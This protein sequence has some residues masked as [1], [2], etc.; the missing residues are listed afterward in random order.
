MERRAYF[1]IGDILANSLV[2][3]AAVALSAWL[4]GGGPGMWPG[5][6]AG[7][8]LGMALALVLSMLLAPLLGVM[9]VMVPCM[10][11][12]MLGGMW[13]G[14]WPLAGSDLPRWGVATAFA[15]LTV[16]YLANALLRGPQQVEP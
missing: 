10:L 13:G 7:M 16:V 15:V 8:V 1:V 5:M 4:I 2:A 12:G 3:T 14:M 6:L 11:S 9:E